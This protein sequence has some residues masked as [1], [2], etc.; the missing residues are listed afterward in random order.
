M[1]CRLHIKAS[2]GVQPV[3]PRPLLLVICL[4]NEHLQTNNSAL[5]RVEDPNEVGSYPIYTKAAHRIGLL[6]FNNKFLKERF[7]KRFE[8]KSGVATNEKRKCF[9]L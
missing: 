5:S 8:G 9:Q 1:I 3:S 6:V 2:T 4:L 7:L